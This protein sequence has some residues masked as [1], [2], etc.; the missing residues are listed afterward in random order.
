MLGPAGLAD[1]ADIMTAHGGSLENLEPLIEPS[2][3]PEESEWV[4]IKQFLFDLIQTI[5]L[6]VLLYLAINAM[7]ARVRVDGLSMLP[8]LQN[9]EYVLVSK[10]SYTFSQ[11]K[12]GDIIVFKFPGETP[13]QDL[14]KRIIGVPGDVVDAVNG[15]IKV[16][17][18][19]LSEPYIA[20]TPFYNGHWEVPTGML[21][22]LGDNRND[23]SD[24]HA[25]G[26]V[27]IENVIG[28]AIVIYWPPP[29]WKLVN[30][31]GPLATP[32][33]LP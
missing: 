27:P 21:F 7:S 22:V 1:G 6:A 28:K 13:E 14:I 26:F 25:W 5:G 4:N 32:T 24:S 18:I 16:N 11:P 15:V 19:P 2:A 23:S 33:P 8:T 31:L 10:I 29:D 12:Y 9:G 17:G 30:H 20:E 3:T